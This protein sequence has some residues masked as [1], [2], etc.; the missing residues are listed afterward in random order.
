MKYD[1][2]AWKKGLSFEGNI[3]YVYNV[4]QIIKNMSNIAPFLEILYHTSF[5]NL[6]LYHIGAV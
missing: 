2:S 6:H 4:F 3:F 5:R 1:R